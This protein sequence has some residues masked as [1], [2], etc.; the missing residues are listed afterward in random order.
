ML[1][2]I[3]FMMPLMLFQQFLQPEKALAS[4]RYGL[5]IC[6][7]VLFYERLDSLI[8]LIRNSKHLYIMN[9]FLHTLLGSS[10]DLAGSFVNRIIIRDVRQIFSKNLIYGLDI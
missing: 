2:A 5:G 8:P 9:D 3:R 1:S 4:I 10:F 6:I 7:N